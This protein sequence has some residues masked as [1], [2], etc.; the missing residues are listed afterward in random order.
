MGLT[1]QFM[2]AS[3]SDT[4]ASEVTV[5][6]RSELQ[7]RFDSL[8]RGRVRG[9]P[10]S[11]STP[12]S[13]RPYANFFPDDQKRALLISS[14]CV[15]LFGET[16]DKLKAT[17]NVLRELESFLGRVPDGMVQFAARMFYTHCHDV[18]KILKL[19]TLAQAQPDSQLPSVEISK[20]P[21]LN[22]K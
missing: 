17:E 2:D 8:L 19:P 12:C 5:P 16:S 15:S 4:S 22:A 14:L 10:A 1:S 9:D 6:T 11:Q 7:A 3:T 21:D 20:S 18:Q 13:S